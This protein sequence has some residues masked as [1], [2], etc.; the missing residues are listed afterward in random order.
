M[1]LNGICDFISA[2]CCLL[3]ITVWYP[4]LAL[5][6]SLA[7]C[8]SNLPGTFL[9]LPSL[10]ISIIWNM[11][12]HLA[13]AVRCCCMILLYVQYMMHTQMYI[14]YIIYTLC[15]SGLQNLNSASQ[16]IACVGICSNWISFVVSLPDFF[17][18]NISSKGCDGGVWCLPWIHREKRRLALF[19]RR[20]ALHPQR[21]HQVWRCVRNEQKNGNSSCKP[22]APQKNRKTK[23][24]SFWLSLTFR[25]MVSLESFCTKRWG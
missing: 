6:E 9:V 19:T 3:L 20:R 16:V 25:Q 22:Q 21:C 14:T 4:F 17:G 12:V 1:F 5:E 10:V 7:V 13:P 24:L 18:R 8:V 23:Y 11:Y 15:F 2:L